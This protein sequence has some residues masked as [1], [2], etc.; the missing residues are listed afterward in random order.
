MGNNPDRKVVLVTGATSGIG[1]TI[2]E[3]LHS[4]GYIVYGAA[5]RPNNLSSSSFPVLKLDVTSEN[6]AI[7][8]VNSVI[9]AEKKIDVL[10][11]N[12]GFGIAGPIEENSIEEAKAQFD[13]NYF[14]VVRMC[15]AVIPHMRDAGNGLIINISS[16]GGII[17]V[18]FQAHYCASKFAVEGL[19]E[20]L[21]LEVARF[22][23]KVV[24]IEPGDFKTGFP[25]CR[26]ID[27]MSKSE[28][29]YN[30]CFMNSIKMMEK[31]ELHGPEPT[32]V[33]HQVEKII[34]TKSPRLRYTVAYPPQN[35]IPPLKR[36]LPWSAIEK[37]IAKNYR[38]DI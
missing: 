25:S 35:L 33:A 2:A 12:A 37:I 24:L 1:K 34:K 13:T 19:S 17:C 4:K 28:S 23:I 31:G 38:I 16:I 20:G 30:P 9:E 29:P 18:P 26:R 5:R 15:K 36:L 10:V 21:R 7:D 6:S 8:C 3:H 32:P 27:D 14:G 11:N 22:G